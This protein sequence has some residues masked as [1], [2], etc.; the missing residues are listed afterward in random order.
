MATQRLT[1]TYSTGY[2]I[3]PNY[4]LLKIAPTAEVDGAGVYAAAAVKIENNGL[5]LAGPGADGVG[6]HPRG[7]AGN[8]SVYL[9]TGNRV[10]NF[11]TIEAGDGGAGYAYHAGSYAGAGGAG[12]AG[13]MLG[14]LGAV[15]N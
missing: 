11:D 9:P 2:T 10:V 8:A 14:A 5:I 7:H 12:G 1:G 3:S 6:G 15:T 4:A 13:V